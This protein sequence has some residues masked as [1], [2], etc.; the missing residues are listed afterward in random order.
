MGGGG[1]NIARYLTF[2]RKNV[3][4]V[5]GRARQS[6]PRHLVIFTSSK[7]PSSQQPLAQ[8][9]A[10]ILKSI[11]MDVK[12]SVMNVGGHVNDTVSQALLKNV[13]SQPNDLANIQSEE[14]EKAMLQTQN[15]IQKQF[16]TQ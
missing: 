15:C 5:T 7:F 8:A 14:L 4:S 3:F 12:I 13:V 9:G 10:M 6:T 11:G 16:Q 1:G 2:A